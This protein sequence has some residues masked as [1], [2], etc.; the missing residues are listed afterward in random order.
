MTFLP[1]EISIGSTVFV[2]PILLMPVFRS[3]HIQILFFVG[4]II[5]IRKPRSVFHPNA[6]RSSAC[7]SS[8]HGSPFFLPLLRMPRRMRR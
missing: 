7:V 2:G 5:Q 6:R 1:S 3:I 8:S 4:G